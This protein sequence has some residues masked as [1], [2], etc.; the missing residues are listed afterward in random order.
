MA[1]RNLEGVDISDC[2]F[3]QGNRMGTVNQI[4]T[5]DLTMANDA[6]QLLILDAN[7]SARNVRLPPNP[8]RGDYYMIIN[9]AA[10]AVALT[11][12]TSAGAAL[13]PAVTVAQNKGVVVCWTGTAWKAIVG[14]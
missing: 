9:P 12:Q 3:K 2:V 11:L 7:G 6:P 4:L 13:S 1:R 14:A 5:G 8:Q 10:A